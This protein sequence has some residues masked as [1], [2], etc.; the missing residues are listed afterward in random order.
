MIAENVSACA[1]PEHY[2]RDGMSRTPI[3]IKLPGTFKEVVAKALQTPPPKDAKVKKR[4][5]KRASK[6]K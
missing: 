5:P 2:A 6:A 4:A 1:A 3:L